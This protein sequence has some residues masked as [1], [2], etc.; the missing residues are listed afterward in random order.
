VFKRRRYLRD[1]YVEMG[2]VTFPVEFSTGFSTS[3]EYTGEIRMISV[4]WHVD[5]LL[6]NDREINNYTRAVAKEWLCKQRSLLGNDP[7]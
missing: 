1:V 2:I 6:S 4:L 5:P 7:N 3:I